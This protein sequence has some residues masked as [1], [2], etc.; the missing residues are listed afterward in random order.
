MSNK[1]VAVREAGALAEA[2]FTA[3]QVDLI[4]RTICKGATDDE[5]RLFLYQAQ[6]T[7][8][9][10]LAR[11][12]HAVKRWDSAAHR[13]VMSIQTSIDGFRLIAERTGKYA[14]QVGPFWCGSDGEWHDVWLDDKP[15]VAARVGVLRT[16]FK[17]TCWAVARFKSYAQTKRD[18]GLTRTWASMPDLMVAKCAE[19]LALRKAFPQELSGLYTSDEMEQASP[20]AAS[21]VPA[22]TSVQA[23]TQ[24]P[25]TEPPHDPETGEIVPHTIAVQPSPGGGGSD[26]ITWGGSLIAAL[27]A[28]ASRDEGE[29]W[30]VHN[31]AALANCETHAPKAHASIMRAAEAMRQRLP[32]ARTIDAEA[33]PDMG[34]AP[35]YLTADEAADALR[36]GV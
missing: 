8:L 13:E 34:D 35:D 12:V 15:P 3:D 1:A 6:K 21:D 14:G 29:A 25:R 9:D 27:K 26:W 17:E 23:A 18:G 24:A 28:S 20:G 22:H 2:R 10:P 5:L 30:L 4:R 36:M 11:Q 16:D 33:E 31:R 32:E 19:S 7:G